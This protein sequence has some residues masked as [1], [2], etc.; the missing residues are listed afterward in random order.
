MSSNSKKFA[1]SYK[2][3]QLVRVFEEHFESKKIRWKGVN[4]YWVDSETNLV[5]RSRQEIHPYEDTINIE[6]YYK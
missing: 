4:L 3:G 5:L 6:F 1:A 2:N